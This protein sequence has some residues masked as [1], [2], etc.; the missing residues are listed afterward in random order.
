MKHSQIRDYFNNLIINTS[1]L[2]F[3][4]LLS[5]LSTEY[6]PKSSI[7]PSSPFLHSNPLFNHSLT[8]LIHLSPLSSPISF[9]LME[10]V[11]QSNLN[12]LLNMFKPTKTFPFHQLYD[13]FLPTSS[14][15]YLTFYYNSQ[16]TI[17]ISITK[18]QTITALI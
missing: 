6:S 12:H 7:F 15:I 18:Q 2:Q 14:L 9:S 10:L 8:T 16:L 17:L 4:I 11:W 13:W 3:P 1:F 5:L